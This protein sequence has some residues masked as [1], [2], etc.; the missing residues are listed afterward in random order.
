MDGEGR[1]QRMALGERRAMLLEL[2]VRLFSERSY[3]EVSIDEIAAVAGVSKGLLYHYFGG[4]QDFHAACVQHGADRLVEAVRLDPSLPEPEQVV[5]ALEAYLAFVEDHSRLFLVVM[6]GGGGA[7]VQAVV[8]ATRQRIVD[9]VVEALDPG[10]GD[11]E[12]RVGV[13]AFL[14][15]VEHASLA[16][17]RAGAP[18]R[19]RVVAILLSALAG[20]Q[21]ARAAA[22]P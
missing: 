1:Q 15:A 10:A 18:P 11:V 9:A 4:K 13:S 2:G 12:V 7:G 8:D 17:L 6:R 14:G 3:E 16:W 5:A 19:D 22:T 21:M 20:L